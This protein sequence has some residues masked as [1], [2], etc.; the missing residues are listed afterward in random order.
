MKRILGFLT[1]ATTMLSANAGCI[2]YT[3]RQPNVTNLIREHGGWAFA[4]YDTICEKLKRANAGIYIVAESAVL[5]NQS[6]GWASVAV[7]DKDTGIMLG[8][9]PSM[10]TYADSYASDDKARELMWHAIND[11]IDKWD[12]GLD[13]ALASLNQER[14]KIKKRYAP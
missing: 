9:Y 14:Q 11:A 13:N 4:N 10:S 5:G 8:D 3:T 1:A 7:K 12:G 6:I 2:L